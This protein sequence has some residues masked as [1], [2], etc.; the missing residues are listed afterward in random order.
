MH[1][2]PLLG[3]GRDKQR[4]F[5]TGSPSFI[6]HSLDREQ[7]TQMV[8]PVRFPEKPPLASRRVT[9]VVIVTISCV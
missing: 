7:G 6:L 9:V 8:L 3:E 4:G 1:S 2:C 5:Y